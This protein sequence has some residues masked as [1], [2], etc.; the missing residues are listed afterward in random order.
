MAQ[1]S[2]LCVQITVAVARLSPVARR[3]LVPELRVRHVSSVARLILSQ[4]GH[5]RFLIADRKF[6]S[7]FLYW[8]RQSICHEYDAPSLME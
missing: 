6:F 5:H 1:S 2:A 7:A 3:C 8:S 4:S